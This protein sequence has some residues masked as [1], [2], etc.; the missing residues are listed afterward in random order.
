MVVRVTLPSK[1]RSRSVKVAD[2]RERLLAPA[3]VLAVQQYCILAFETV[4][5]DLV[6]AEALFDVSRACWPDE[7]DQIYVLVCLSSMFSSCTPAER[8]SSAQ[9]LSH[10]SPRRHSNHRGKR[11][12]TEDE[13]V[14]A[15]LH[16]VP[17]DRGSKAR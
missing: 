10:S 15:L 12:S 8:T 4:P 17:E 9:G 3:T 14:A 11:E 1:R 2:C 7:V 5:A 13:V 16:N 6:F